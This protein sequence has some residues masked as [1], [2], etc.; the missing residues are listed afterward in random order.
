MSKLDVVLG[1]ALFAVDI[2]VQKAGPSKKWQDTTHFHVDSEIHIIL[3][4]GARIEIDGKDVEMTEGDVCLL[5][6]RSSH[7]PKNFGENLEKTNFSFS[8]MKNYGYSH[9]KRTFS[10]Y[11]YYSRLFGSVDEY[12][13]INDSELTAIA[14]KLI[15]EQFSYETE[16]IFTSLL[17]VFLIT[18]GKRI[19]EHHPPYK[20][21]II[22]K[23]TENENAA[24]QRKTVE[25]FFQKRYSE[26]ISIED[27]AK[28]LCLSVP[29]THRIVKKVFES[30]FK[31]T[32]MKQR[33][34]HAC[35][36]IKQNDLPLA[37]IAYQCGYTSYN[38]FLSAFK[39]YTGRTPKEYEKSVK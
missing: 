23:N 29:H 17:S 8:L 26:E 16:H 39:S 20:E 37:E 31:K 18:L 4:D 9:E 6:P 12:F 30:G 11:A 35:M 38:G 10:E 24:R 19:G 27:L 15:E 13:I 1:D 34:E 14:K 25:E 28:D 5:A 22:H 32:L 36:L 3:K 21:Q 33:I 7:Y 2:D